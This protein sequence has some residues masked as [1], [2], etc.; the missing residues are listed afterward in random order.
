[1]ERIAFRSTSTQALMAELHRQDLLR[2]AAGSR[3][4]PEPSIADEL[5]LLARDVTRRLGRLRGRQPASVIVAHPN[6]SPGRAIAC[7]D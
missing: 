5:R 2:E 4:E 1:M 7:T 3:V 6:S